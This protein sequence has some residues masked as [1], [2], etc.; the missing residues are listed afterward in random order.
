VMMSPQGSQ[1]EKRM[2]NQAICQSYFF[3]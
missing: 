1:M 2:N 3:E